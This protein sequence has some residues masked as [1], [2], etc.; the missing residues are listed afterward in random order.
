MKRFAAIL[1]I[2]LV[3]GFS[4]FTGEAFSWTVK[5]RNPT[6]TRVDVDLHY[7]LP[8]LGGVKSAQLTNG[9][10]HT[11]ELGADCP[12]A[13]TGTSGKW[14]RK[15]M[16]TDMHGTWYGDIATAIAAV[17]CANFN[18]KICDMPK[19]HGEELSFCIDR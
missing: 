9:Q 2:V 4:F 16:G 6:N 10:E 5:V 7:G 11:F 14:S 3:A 1:L 8:L 18:I 13:L 15:M 19:G 17:S 12:R